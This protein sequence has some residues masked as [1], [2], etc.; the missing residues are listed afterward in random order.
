MMVIM[1]ANGHAVTHIISITL[2]RTHDYKPHWKV[3]LIYLFLKILE[4]KVVEKS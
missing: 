4:T 1:R 2:K 3:D